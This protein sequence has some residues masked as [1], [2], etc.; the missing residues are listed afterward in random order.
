MSYKIKI[1]YGNGHWFSINAIGIPTKDDLKE[2]LIGYQAK[3]NE[4][5]QT[6]AVIEQCKIPQTIDPKYG[7]TEYCNVGFITIM[8]M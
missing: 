5:M 8:E 7:G 4:V 1:H 6:L 3:S 2:E